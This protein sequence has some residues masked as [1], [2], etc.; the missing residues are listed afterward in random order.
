VI[1][2]AGTLFGGAAAIAGLAERIAARLAGRARGATRL[3]VAITSK[4]GEQA[5]G[6]AEGRVASTQDELIDL[7]AP[8]VRQGAGPGTRLRVIV[9][10][11]EVA[12][13]DAVDQVA[14][15]ALPGLPRADA[16][17][18]QAPLGEVVPPAPGQ[19]GHAAPWQLRATQALRA[20]E[21]RE[22][23]RRTRRARP[24]GREASLAQPQLFA[25]LDRSG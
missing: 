12:D 11:E 23:H 7:I 2:N 21:G 19:P 3:E 4:T 25:N 24:P 18:L 14:V 16:S 17:V 15:N 1:G 22:A 8:L 6:V 5:V 13:A 9:V 10:A 20:G